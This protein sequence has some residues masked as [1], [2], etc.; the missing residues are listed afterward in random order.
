M[1]IRMLRFESGLLSLFAVAALLG[2][3]ACS[4]DTTAAEEA[5]ETTAASGTGTE[6]ETDGE[7]D[8]SDADGETTTNDDGT[9]IAEEGPDTSDTAGPGN[10]GDMCADDGDCADDLFCYGLP[11]L[12]G[13]CSECGG[14][15]DCDGGN[16]TFN[17]MWFACGEGN[18]G[19]MCET[20]DA[21]ADGLYCAEI[22]NVG[23]L[24]AGNFCSECAEDAHCA[25]GQLC[26]PEFEL[27]GAMGPEGQR[28][29]IDAGTHPQDSLCDLGGSG[30]EQCEGFCTEVDIMMLI[31]LGVCGECESDED[32]M[33]GTCTPAAFGF[34]LEGSTCN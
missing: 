25:D 30:D 29:C 34:G 13:I 2:T 11:G 18:A 3:S 24:F 15:S 9:F 28:V 32:C 10:L 5:G 19:E 23:G 22:V 26:A 21:C 27:M 17:G 14:D 12:G 16:C 31:T 1:M 7:T 8:A 20:D 4:D 33:G 6:T